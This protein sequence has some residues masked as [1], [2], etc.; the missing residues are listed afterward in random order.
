MC[1]EGAINFLDLFFY[2][3][4]TA[5]YETRAGTY[6]RGDLTSYHRS[7]E[8][9]RVNARLW[10]ISVSCLKMT[11]RLSSWR[12]LFVLAEIKIVDLLSTLIRFFNGNMIPN[13]LMRSKCFAQVQFCR[14]FTSAHRG[15]ENSH[16]ILR[17]YLT[18]AQ[19][20]SRVYSS[21]ARANG[22]YA[23]W[24]AVMRYEVFRWSGAEE[25]RKARARIGINN[26]N[27]E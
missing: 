16:C 14:S 2:Q 1:R 9:W 15:R 7:L 23:R 27:R 17:L 22:L 3:L 5:V 18:L 6:E 21:C 24:Q 26:I 8:P 20:R 11:C 25:F 4:L 19:S 10:A 13:P 12:W